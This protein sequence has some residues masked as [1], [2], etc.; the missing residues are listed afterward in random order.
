MSFDILQDKIR[1]KK[2]PLAAGLGA[3]LDDIP[4]HILNQHTAQH[5][6]TLEA[7]AG[8]ALEFHLGLIDAIAGIVPAVEVQCAY[9]EALGWRGMKALEEVAARARGRGLFVIAGGMREA[10]GGPAAAYSAAWLGETTVGSAACP[11]FSA[12]CVTLGGYM[13]SDGVQPFL[14][15][16][17]ARNKCA[18]VLAKSSNPSSA[19]FQDLVSGDRLVYTAMGDLIQRWGRGTAGKYGYQALGAVVGGAQPAA[20]KQLRRRLDRTFFLVSGCAA[21]D[22]RLADVRPA[23]DELGRG[24]AVSDSRAALLAWKAAGG[25]GSDYRD[26]ARDAAER[27]RDGLR[28]SVAIF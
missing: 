9:F 26:A 28:Q 6:E 16:C 24:A 21:Q 7:A 13:G 14:K 17:T 15:D 12:D 8:A 2:N 5:G 18:F 20:L 4:P 25:D 1:A 10:A 23:F 22:G 27:L 19:E 11:V 3:G